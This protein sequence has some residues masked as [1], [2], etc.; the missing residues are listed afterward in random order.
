MDENAFFD[1]LNAR[2]GKLDGVCIS[3]GEPL[4]QP[5]LT[6]FIKKIRELG[7]LVKIDTNGSNFEKLKNILNQN[8]VDYVAMDIKNTPE[9]YAYSCGMSV[10]VN[11]VKKSVDLIKNSGIR[12]EFR[13][14][15]V[16]ELNDIQDFKQIARWLEGCDGYYLQSY[17]ESEKVLRPIYT[18]YTQ[19]E[20]KNILFLV[21]ESGLERVYL[22]GI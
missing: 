11:S 13:T 14:T 17:R 19:E 7:F 20:M 18:A 8:L 6:E 2:K 5:D 15:V 16:K 10:D 9:K 12:H 21:K 3:G 1:F 22:R 4:L